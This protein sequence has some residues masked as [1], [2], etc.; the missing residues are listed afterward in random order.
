MFFIMLIGRISLGLLATSR[1]VLVTSRH[2]SRDSSMTLLARSR[3]ISRDL[4]RSVMRGS[5]EKLAGLSTG[6]DF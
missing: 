2:F 5:R 1:E 4:A 3:E 6:E